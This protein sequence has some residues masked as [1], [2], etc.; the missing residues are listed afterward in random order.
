M[1]ELP[2]KALAQELIGKSRE[3]ISAAPIEV[4][5]RSGAQRGA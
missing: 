5:H 1:A 4:G 3:E 2:G